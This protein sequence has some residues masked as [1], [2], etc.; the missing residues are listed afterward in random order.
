M[1]DIVELVRATAWP[2]TTLTIILLMRSELRRM[3][4]AFAYRIQSAHSIVVG[5]KG[6]EI[7][8][9]ADLSSADVQRRRLKVAR[10]INTLRTKA[11]LDQIC[12]VLQIDKVSNL[13][14]ERRSIIDA[15]ASRVKTSDDLDEVSAL[16]REATGQ[17]F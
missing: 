8:G 5:R 7:K 4:D 6:L 10:F 12:D 13:K 17:D 14:A 11:E 1:H 15:V 16:L 3:G 9:V 2:I